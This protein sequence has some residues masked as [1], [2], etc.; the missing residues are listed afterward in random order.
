MCAAKRTAKPKKAHIPKAADQINP[1]FSPVMRFSRPSP[2]VD[3]PLPTVE[4][5][6]KMSIVSSRRAMPRASMGEEDVSEIIAAV[7]TS[8]ARRATTDRSKTLISIIFLPMRGC[9]GPKK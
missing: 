7:A 2:I 3:M 9:E 1:F 6:R 4:T 5:I 8:A